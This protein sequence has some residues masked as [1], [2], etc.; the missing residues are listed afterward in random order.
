M[1]MRVG[2]A[3]LLVGIAT[4]ADAGERSACRNEP[5]LTA[6]D[7]PACADVEIDERLQAALEKGDLSVLDELRRRYEAA[8]TDRERHSLSALLLEYLDDDTT[9]WNDLSSEAA[10]CLRLT[11]ESEE[12][13]FRAKRYGVDPS[14]LW[15]RSQSALQA[16][17]RDPRAQSL[18]LEAR[19]R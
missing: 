7:A 18:L 10:V 19:K 15:W 3:M 11:V 2:L 14:L 6:F 13:A 8:L 16:I 12:L 17:S 9:I 4:V 5:P 1:V